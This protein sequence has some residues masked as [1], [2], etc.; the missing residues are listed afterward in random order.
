MLT[1]KHSFRTQA[2]LLQPVGYKLFVLLSFLH[3]N[4][5][6]YIFP[7]YQ[8]SLGILFVISSHLVLLLSKLVRYLRSWVSHRQAVHTFCTKFE[9]FGV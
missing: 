4:K 7:A 1:P 2:F 9:T 8:Y 3:V 6:L 5:K